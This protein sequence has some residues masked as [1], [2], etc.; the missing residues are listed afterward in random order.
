MSESV[1]T[2]ESVL[3]EKGFYIGVLSGKSMRPTLK[4]RVDTIVVKAKTGRLSYLDVALFKRDGEYVLHRVVGVYED[5]Y[6]MRGDNCYAD[7]WVDE[8]EVLGILMEFYHGEKRV[9]CSD[10]AYLRKVKTRLFF[11][12]F[13][14]SFVHVKAYVL[15]VFRKK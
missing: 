7:E 8:K 3:N 5:G 12:P 4:E 11:Y 14:L 9:S 13:R 2:I 15:R 1:Q 6:L 10:K